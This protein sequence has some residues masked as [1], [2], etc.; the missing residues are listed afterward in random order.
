MTKPLY[1][2]PEL[3]FLDFTEQILGKAQ[4]KSVPVLE[5]FWFADIYTK[6]ISE[7]IRSRV[8]PIKN[9]IKTNR[10][11]GIQ[12][13]SASKLLK[14]IR[15][16]IVE[17]DV[18]RSEI[19]SSLRKELS[20]DNKV[21]ALIWPE[22]NPCE[23]S[24]DNVQDK[25]I[26]LHFPYHSFEQ[27]IKLLEEVADD[28]DTRSI[29]VSMYRLAP[30]SAVVERLIKAVKNG[31]KVT[32]YVETEARL[33]EKSNTNYISLMR[34]N[35]IRIIPKLDGW[36]V[37]A[38]LI[39]IKFKE[40]KSLAIISTGN[41]HEGTAQ[42]YSDISL[43]TCDPHITYGVNGVFN[44][45]RKREGKWADWYPLVVSPVDVRE[46]FIQLIDNEISYAR[47]GTKAEIIVKC[48]GLTDVPLAKKLIEAI[49]AGVKVALIIRGMNI[50][51]PNYTHDNLINH[52]IVDRFL[53]HARIFSFYNNRNPRIYLGSAD[54][55]GR[56]LDKR[57]EVTV[58]IQDKDIKTMLDK[59]LRFQIDN[60]TK[61]QGKTQRLLCQK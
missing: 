47:G 37:H 24:L 14:Q 54:W 30:D 43:L 38:K 41:L 19:Y 48:N 4:D 17:L 40:K 22:H 52:R 58:E 50:I 5:R 11:Y 46:Y 25:D 8:V 7:F 23:V 57:I 31:K 29:T 55:M 32:A 44:F 59:I 21:P 42:S 35:G 45:I 12:D 53:E 13:T 3:S 49:K 34:T 9:K 39:L 60:P 20:Q 6:N 28:T 51:N 18:K 26:L 1:F 27:I 56:N 16:R 33:D 2:P 15:Q 10:L 36:K 61:A